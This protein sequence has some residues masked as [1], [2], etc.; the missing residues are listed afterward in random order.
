M[1]H[2]HG[3]TKV[4][5]E[6]SL[7]RAKFIGSFNPAGVKAYASKIE[8]LLTQ[9]NGQPFI[10]LIDNLQLVGGTPEAYKVLDEYNQWLNGQNLVAKAIVIS[11]EFKAKIIDSL[12]PALKT[13]NMRYFTEKK[14]ALD[15]LETELAFNIE[16]RTQGE[17]S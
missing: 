8:G 16:H 4:A 10:M 7:I 15:W 11:S 17:A 3:E 5:L 13:Q 6:G 1:S 2:E 12:T 9:L 14:E